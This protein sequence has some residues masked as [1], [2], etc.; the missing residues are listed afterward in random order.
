MTDI[1]IVTSI[2]LQRNSIT[3]VQS[4]RFVFFSARFFHCL[5][6]FVFM[7]QAANKPELSVIFKEL[8]T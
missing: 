6:I 8:Q 3:D 1:K 4:P 2:S 5:P 7:P